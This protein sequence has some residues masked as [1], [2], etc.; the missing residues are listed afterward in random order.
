MPLQASYLPTPSCWN[1]LMSCVSGY[2]A[3][4]P[5]SS[6][7]SC[8]G[9]PLLPRVTWSGPAP[10][11]YSSPPLHNN[12]SCRAVQWP[13]SQRVVLRPLEVR[14]TMAVAPA[15]PAGLPRPPVVVQRV[16]PHV[17]HGVERGGA[18]PDPA[19][20]PVQR[21]PVRSSLGLRLVEPGSHQVWSNVEAVRL[22]SCND[23]CRGC[24]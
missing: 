5:A 6:H 8:S 2:P 10:P 20:R 19:P 16:P 24:K 4:W 23:L 1:P 15:L 9:L 13:H 11:R 22:A 21:P 18:A 14:Q 17:D 7:A 3:C 12:V